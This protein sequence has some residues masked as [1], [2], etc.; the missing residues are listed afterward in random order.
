MFAVQFENALLGERSL[1]R[2]DHL[3]R[4]LWRAHGAGA[5]SDNEAQ[6]LAEMLHDG[7]GKAR[8]ARQAVGIPVGRISIFRPRRYQAS[9]DRAASISRRRKLAAS[10][11]LPPQIACLFTTSEQACLAVVGEQVRQNGLCALSIDEI[12]ARAGCCRSTCKNALRLAAAEGL[13][14]VQ[15]RRRQGKVNL[16]NILRIVSSAWLAWLARRPKAIG[17]KNTSPTDTTGSNPV[18][19]EAGSQH[20]GAFGE[21]KRRNWASND[22][23][24]S[25]WKSSR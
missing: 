16:T 14:V 9:P 18:K 2:I 12:A 21:V 13:L 10:G 23:A 6:R 8:E 5:I 1:A 7:R 19:T 25:A 3:S 20:F 22:A 17:V 15:E 11:P 24:R 4:D